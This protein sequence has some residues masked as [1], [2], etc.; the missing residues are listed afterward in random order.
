MKS[1]LD[2]DSMGKIICFARSKSWSEDKE[3]TSASRRLDNTL[4][5]LKGNIQN[6]RSVGGSNLNFHDLEQ[7]LAIF[8]SKY[9]FL[10]HDACHLRE[11]HKKFERK[12]GTWILKK[13][14]MKEEFK[15][16]KLW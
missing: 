15:V 11:A 4:P 6:A 12:Q 13:I 8:T 5:R 3:D 14:Y 16:F 1:L 10:K 7:D 9:E 2:E